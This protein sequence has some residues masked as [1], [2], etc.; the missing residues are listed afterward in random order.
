M[1]AI[2][3][4]YRI[5]RLEAFRAPFDPASMTDDELRQCMGDTLQALDGREA[6]LALMR[7]IPGFDPET[8]QT[9]EE[10][11]AWPL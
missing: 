9:V 11:P 1:S 3:L 2:S 8:I 4:A 5:S 6:A 10:W 7:S